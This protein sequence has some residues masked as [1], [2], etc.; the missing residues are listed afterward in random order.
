MGLPRTAS[1]ECYDVELLA[2]ANERLARA[3][4]IQKSRNA[5]FEFESVFVNFVSVFSFVAEHCIDLIFR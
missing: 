2:K 5:N 3:V 4:D 1:L